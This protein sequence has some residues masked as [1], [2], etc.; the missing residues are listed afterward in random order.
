[1]RNFRKFAIAAILLTASGNAGAEET[2]PAPKVESTTVSDT[3]MLC[4]HQDAPTGSHI[5]AKSVCHTVAEWRNIHANSDE[6][7]R[8]LDVLRDEAIDGNARANGR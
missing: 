4:V 1:M 7:M 5:G 8:H 6:I 3:R 2:A